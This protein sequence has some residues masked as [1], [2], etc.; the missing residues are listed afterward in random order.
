MG[1]FLVGRGFVFLKQ[2]INSVR[3]KL[4]VLCSVGSG[5]N[6][7]LVFKATVSLFGPAYSGT[8]LG[9]G[10][11]S[12][13]QF[14]SESFCYAALV[15][16]TYE[17]LESEPRISYLDLE[18]SFS[19]PFPVCDCPHTLWLPGLHFLCSLFI[20]KLSPFLWPKSRIFSQFLVPVW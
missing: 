13:P 6:A 3:F 18:D 12:I 16:S 20:K 4:Q 2:L 5:S 19:Q 15:D 8:S 1:F 10:R 9:S 7:N 14:S 17:Q 11:W